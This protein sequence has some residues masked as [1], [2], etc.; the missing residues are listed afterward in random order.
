MFYLY[1]SLDSHSCTTYCILQWSWVINEGFEKETNS[2][3]DCVI[4]RATTI[5]FIIG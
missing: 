3:M 1:L 2:F 5:I 4:S